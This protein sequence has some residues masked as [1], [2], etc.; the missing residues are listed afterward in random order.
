VD[1]DP[2]QFHVTVTFDELGGKTRLTMRSVFKTAEQLNQVKAFDAVELGNQTLAR[3]E[4]F[5]SALT[6]K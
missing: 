4:T 3:L 2:Q 1:N 6:R 5:V